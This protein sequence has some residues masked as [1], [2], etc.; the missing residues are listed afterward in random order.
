MDVMRLD[1]QNWI[2][3]GR[4]IDLPPG[5]VQVERTGRG[6][7]AVFRGA[8]GSLHALLDRCPHGGGRLS[9]GQVCDCDVICPLRGCRVALATGWSDGRAGTRVP[10]FPVKLEDGKVYVSLVPALEE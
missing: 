4:L 5:G 1:I 3:V 2:L 6:P 7:I 10:R 9:D 8:D